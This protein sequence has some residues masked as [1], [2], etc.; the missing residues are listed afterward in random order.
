MNLPVR[1]IILPVRNRNQMAYS[2]HCSGCGKGIVLATHPL[3]SEKSREILEKVGWTFGERILCDGCS[4]LM[5]Y[6][7]MFNSHK[8]LE[9]RQAMIVKYGESVNKWME[10]FEL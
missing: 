3:T 10:R 7:E 8:S 6:W 5:T 9:Y 1:K 2:P 4:C